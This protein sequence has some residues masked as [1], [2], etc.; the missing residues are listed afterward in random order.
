MEEILKDFIKKSE[1]RER[2]FIQKQEVLD[3]L[4]IEKSKELDNLKDEIKRSICI[5]RSIMFHKHGCLK[6]V[7]PLSATTCK[8]LGIGKDSPIAWLLPV[9]EEYL[10]KEI[11]LENKKTPWIGGFFK[12]IKT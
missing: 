4:F 7:H 5:F 1:E 9:H 11:E 6:D 2:L 3:N 8:Y 12:T 10:R